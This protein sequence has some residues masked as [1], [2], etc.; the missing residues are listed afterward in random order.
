MSDKIRVLIVDDLPIMREAIKEVLSGEPSI[1]VVGTAKDADEA[2]RKTVA[3][4]PSVITMDINMPGR[5]GLEA[6][7]EIMDVQPTSI[8]VL[9][10]MD[11][12]VIVKSLGIGAMDF[13]KIDQDVEQVSR[14]L[15]DKIRIA[16]R[17][18]PMRHVLHR[19]VKTATEE[20]KTVGLCRVVAIGVSTGGPQAL[21]SLLSG[22]P[23]NFPAAIVIVQHMTA[24]FI[25]GLADW[26]RSN[27]AL[28]ICVAKAGERL[29]N[30]TVYLAPDTYNLR[31]SE[32]PTIIL[33]E[34]PVKM[35]HVPSIDVMM[36]SVAEVHGPRAIGV[37]L[38]GM[39]RDGVDGIIE[40]KKAGG[41]TIAQDEKSSAVF[42]M[43]K[44]A[45]DSGCV[46]IVAPIDKIAQEL[47]R[48]VS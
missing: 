21:T 38:T 12:K 9:S 26:L 44:L 27:T 45:I 3:L 39:G 30:S 6:I 7:E 13:V 25:D 46:D 5:S 41:M 35:T 34:P 31:M 19:P 42:G 28:N 48:L 36:K 20:K 40:I 18:R 11:V 14:E 32:G 15:I 22:L 43:N 37:I 10:N 8:I 2:V 24:G 17:V 1:E 47:I 16:S 23:A 29:K 4:K 33:S